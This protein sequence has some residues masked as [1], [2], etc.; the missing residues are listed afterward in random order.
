VL[1]TG[2]GFSFFRVGAIRS[3][4]RRAARS[5]SW[6]TATASEGA[7]AREKLVKKWR[8]EWKFALIEAGNPEWGDLWEQWFGSGAQ[9]A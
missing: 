3:A 5:A 4:C 2:L 7:I 1:D 8:R 9:Q 6:G